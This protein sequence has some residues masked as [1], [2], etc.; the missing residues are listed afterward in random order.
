MKKYIPLIFILCGCDF[1]FRQD[2]VVSEEDLH[3]N[4]KCEV[5]LQCVYLEPDCQAPMDTDEDGIPDILIEVHCVDQLMEGADDG[6]SCQDLSG[7]R[8]RETTND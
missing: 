6:W 1:Q 8:P 3:C 2:F 7:F 4:R 5:P